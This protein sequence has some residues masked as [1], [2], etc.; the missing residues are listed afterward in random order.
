MKLIQLEDEIKFLNNL[1][2]ENNSQIVKLKQENESQLSAVK[3]DFTNQL[4]GKL[5][6]LNEIK[7]LLNENDSKLKGKLSILEALV[8]NHY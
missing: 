8:F 3:L 4:V 1:C 5:N 6:E 2:H 7:S